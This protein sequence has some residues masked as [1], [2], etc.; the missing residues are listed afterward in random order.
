MSTPGPP[1]GP[2]PG[3][4]R[5]GTTGEPA[6]DAPRRD[7]GRPCRAGPARAA[8]DRAKVRAAGL[9]IASNS[10]LVAGKLVVGVLTGSISIL[11]EA[12]HSASDLVAALIAFFSVRAAAR[13]PDEDHHYGHSKI[14][15]VSGVIEALLIFAAAVW[16]IV[17]SVDK[18][19]HGQTIERLWLAVGVMAG[20]AIL[21]FVVSEGVLYPTARKTE[22]AA[23]EADA[24]HLRTDVYTSVGVVVGLI[25]VRLTGMTW[26]DPVFAILIALLITVTAYR[27]IMRSTRVLLDEA[28][29]QT[30]MELVRRCVESHRGDIIVDYHRLR[31]R[32]AG[33]H[34]YIDLHIQVDEHLTVAEAHDIAHH[35]AADVRE[36]LQNVDVLVHTEPHRER[37]VDGAR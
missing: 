24:A 22:S 6:G 10:L 31:A 16:I 5:P 19:V 17:E 15:N 34:R 23:L 13:P 30:E 33:S 35:I 11:S 9:S 36:C 26:L 21:N 27:L 25:L 14:E 2:H 28:L 4:A 29:P 1:S 3:S 18:L 32:R 7:A 20:S 12:A 37:E 8:A